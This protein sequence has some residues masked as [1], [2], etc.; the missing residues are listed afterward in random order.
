M[1][2]ITLRTRFLHSVH[3][4]FMKEFNVL[5]FVFFSSAGEKRGSSYSKKISVF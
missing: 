2:R 1:V 3:L 5:G 4:V